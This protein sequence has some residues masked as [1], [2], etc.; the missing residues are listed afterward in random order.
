MPRMIPHH[1][2]NAPY[3]ANG[4]PY[5]AKDAPYHVK[6]APYHVKDA[7]YHAKDA[8]TPCQKCY[9]TMPRM[10][11]TMWTYHQITLTL[12]GK[13]LLKIEKIIIFYFILVPREHWLK[14]KYNCMADLL[15]ILFGF[16]CFAYVE[17]T[18]ILLVW[19]NPN[20][21]SRSSGVQWYFPPMASVLFDAL[22]MY[23]WEVSVLKNE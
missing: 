9:H 12:V 10:P 16:S 11:P 19:S 18:T 1:A 8:T 15:F 13:S 2:K 4:A 17:W 22:R 5:H 23:W 7:P 6:D 21:S 20:Q 3:H 14:G